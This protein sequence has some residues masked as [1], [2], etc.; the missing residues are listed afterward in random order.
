MWEIIKAEFCY[1]KFR[2]MLIILFCIICFISIWYGVK[3]EQNKK[4][5]IMLI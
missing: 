3:W 2:I 5:L 1:D 4:P